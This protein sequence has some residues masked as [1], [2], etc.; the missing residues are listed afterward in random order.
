MHVKFKSVVFFI[1]YLIPCPFG[2]TVTSF[3]HMKCK[4]CKSTFW[5]TY[6]I[7]CAC[8]FS[9]MY[10]FA[11][12]TIMTSLAPGYEGKIFLLID[13]VN[14]MATYLFCVAIYLSLITSSAKLIK[15]INGNFAFYDECN[16]LCED[17]RDSIANIIF[18]IRTLYLYIGNFLLNAL[19][20]TENRENLAMVPLLYK[21]LYFIP[22]IIIAATTI[23][24]RS[25]ITVNI[26]CCKRISQALSE[27]FDKMKKSI[28]KSSKVRFRVYA[29]EKHTFE[30][31]V[32]CHGKMY[33]LVQATEV[34]Y[35]N[36]LIFTTLRAFALLSSTVKF[37]SYSDKC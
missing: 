14:Y 19:K 22:D 15:F 2:L 21:C 18:S 12:I 20:L 24:F 11:M 10:P 8:I 16:V 27:C 32:D 28:R 7:I 36:S 9:S 23:R 3:D 5:N 37:T 4:M 1:L 25:G 34:L 6:S 26:M 33:N 17:R 31:I 13:I 29:R 30:K 35:R